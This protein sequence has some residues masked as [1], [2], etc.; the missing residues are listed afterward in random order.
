[1]MKIRLSRRSGRPAFV[2][3]EAEAIK[4][5]PA[6][7]FL[8]KFHVEREITFRRMPALTMA[9]RKFFSVPLQLNLIQ[10]VLIPGPNCN[11]FRKS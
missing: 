10:H 2:I 4:N 5:T 9:I 11:G 6:L 1:M 8:V 3:H 7:C